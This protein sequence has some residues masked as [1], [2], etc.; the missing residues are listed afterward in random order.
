MS[1]LRSKG[2]F[3]VLLLYS[4]SVYTF[5][6]DRSL[7]IFLPVPP[8][9]NQTD[10]LY[11]HSMHSSVIKPLSP[12]HPAQVSVLRFRQV[13]LECIIFQCE[14]K[15]F[16]VEE[17]MDLCVVVYSTISREFPSNTQ[18]I[19]V[20]SIDIRF[21]SCD[22]WWCVSLFSLAALPDFSLLFDLPKRDNGKPVLWHSAR[23]SNGWMDLIPG[24]FCSD[25]S[26]ILCY[27]CTSPLGCLS[28]PRWEER[29][30]LLLI[31][32]QM[33]VSAPSL[34]DPALMMWARFGRLPEVRTAALTSMHPICCVWIGSLSRSPCILTWQALD[35]ISL[36]VGRFSHLVCELIPKLW[37]SQVPREFLC[38]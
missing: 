31:A 32:A 21:K 6:S 3:Q 29:S 36:R 22:I 30:P 11:I 19:V 13:T 1:S 38:L 34:S 12:A 33:D 15:A 23:Q 26:Q 37:V 18:H 2:C 17:W 28:A 25:D 9:L 24:D 27:R 8:V 10:P 4:Y 5:K 16:Y 7:P 14:L 35:F 20:F